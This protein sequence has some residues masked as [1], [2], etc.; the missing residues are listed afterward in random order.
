MML[1]A[2]L[3]V[4]SLKFESLLTY[5]CQRMP[6]L[7]NIVSNTYNQQYITYARGYVLP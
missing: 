5:I 4:H 3:C 6:W 1:V 7:H 2:L